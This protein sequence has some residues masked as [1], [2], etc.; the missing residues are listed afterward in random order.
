MYFFNKTLRWSLV[1]ALGNSPVAKLTTLIPLLGY[2]ILFNKHFIELISLSSNIFEQGGAHTEAISLRLYYIYFGLFFFGI[3]QLIYFWLCPGIIKR[4]GDSFDFVK[5]ATSYVSEEY[6]VQLAAKFGG[7]RDV[8]NK[9]TNLIRKFE[10]TSDKEHHDYQ[11]VKSLL[12][13]DLWYLLNSSNKN[14]VFLCVLLYT[15]GLILLAIPSIEAFT[16]IVAAF[17]KQWS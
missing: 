11:R 9:T 10:E 6:I 1:R 3:G 16:K 17:L 7:D 8:L 13:Y 15:T 14:G 2:L 5:E 12:V 4:W